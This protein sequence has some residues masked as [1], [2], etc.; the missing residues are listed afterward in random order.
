[1]EIAALNSIADTG[2]HLGLGRTKIYELISEGALAAV[3]SGSKTLVTGASIAAYIASLP[4]AD[5]QL[6]RAKREQPAA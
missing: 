6:G 4:R 1:M 3:K 2:R 5:I